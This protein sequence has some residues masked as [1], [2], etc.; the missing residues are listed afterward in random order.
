MHRLENK[1]FGRLTVLW[2]SLRIDKSGH[3]YW[4][5][6]CSCGRKHE[7]QTN[8]LL[9]G[10]TKSCG[11]LAQEMRGKSRI[12]HGETR[13]PRSNWSPRTKMLYAAK[14]RAKKEELPF[15]LT[16]EDIQ[17]PDVCPILGYTLEKNSRYC[18]YNSPSLDKIIPALGYVRGNVQV[19]SHKANTIKNDATI[20]DLEKIVTYMKSR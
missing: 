2:K 17:I 5:C 20:E 9:S 10:N 11:C 13:G 12:T 8:K 4:E 3:I 16:L 1:Q 7:V 15:N 19:I 6:R 18:Q 14:A